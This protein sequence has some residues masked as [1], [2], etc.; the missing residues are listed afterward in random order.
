MVNCTQVLPH[1][2]CNFNGLFLRNDDDGV[3]GSVIAASVVFG[4]EY[5]REVRRNFR[6]VSH[7]RNG[8]DIARGQQQIAHKNFSFCTTIYH[9]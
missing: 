8:I 4:I 7:T 9:K 5:H 2:Y 3:S 1:T 6:F